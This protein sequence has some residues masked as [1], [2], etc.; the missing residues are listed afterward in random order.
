M[1]VGILGKKLGMSQIFTTE[2]HLVP[3]TVVEA[4]PCFVTQLK[5]K[6]R[7]RYSAIQIGFE[8]KKEK[9]LTKPLAG[10]FKKAEV[11]PKRLLRELHIEESDEGNYKLG[12][13]ITTSIFEDALVVP[14]D[15]IRESGSSGSCFIVRGDR[16]IT[17]KVE[18]SRPREG[19][20]M[21][22]AGVSP[23][24]TVITVGTASLKSGQKVALTMK[25]E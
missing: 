5:T 3:V 15:A 9:R 22:T 6:E 10:H 23:G 8:D 2:G 19:F 20:L 11:S 21:L 25:G 18:I 16:V 7:D 13:E 14:Q 24:D 4:G 12:S 17:K 1:T